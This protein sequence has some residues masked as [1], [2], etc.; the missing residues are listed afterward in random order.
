MNIIGEDEG[1]FDIVCDC[2]NGFYVLK[3]AGVAHCLDCDRADDPRR[4]R[5]KWARHNDPFEPDT[6]Q[7]L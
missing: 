4:L 6:C 1:G 7:A 5:Y 3:S 2:G